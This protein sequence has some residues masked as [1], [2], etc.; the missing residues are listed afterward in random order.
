MRIIEKKCPNCGASLEF[1]DK[2]KSC[3]CEYCKRS[4]E[5]ERENSVTGEYNYNLTQ[6]K[7][8]ALFLIIFFIVF[9]FIIFISFTII[10]NINFNGLV[11][12]EKL[13]TDV[14][15]MNS[16]SLTALDAKASWD[17]EKADVELDEYGLEMPAKRQKIYVAYNKKE[18]TNS[19]IAVYKATYKLTFDRDRISIL[20]PI[21]YNNVKNSELGTD[22]A[23]ADGYVKGPE[24]YLNLEHSEYARGYQDIETLEKDIIDPLKK[25]GFKITKK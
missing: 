25:Q 10:K 8:G 7:F 4:F 2:A 20:V 15:E 21:I 17:I 14:S 19:V 9:A 22:M 16:H 3:R 5:I 6:K 23:F 18:K 24:Y 13:Y 11:K 12:N 1:D